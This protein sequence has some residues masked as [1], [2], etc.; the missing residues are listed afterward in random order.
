MIQILNTNYSEIIQFLNVYLINLNQLFNYFNLLKILLLH[1]SLF[2]MVSYFHINYNSIHNIINKL[3]F[4]YSNIQYHIFIN[5]FNFYNVHY[6]INHNVYKLI[7]YN[8]N[9]T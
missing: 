6:L 9:Y 7:N 8:L 1:H 4:T 5:H 3:L 2:Y